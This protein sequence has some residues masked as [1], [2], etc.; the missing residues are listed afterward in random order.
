MT[1]FLACAGVLLV[2][3]LLGYT[4]QRLA[5]AEEPDM[6]EY[7][8]DDDIRR[9]A[10]SG[11]RMLALKWYRQLHA[12]DVKTAMTAVKAMTGRVASGH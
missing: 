4:V 12:T 5:P 3:L 1:T 9:L 11:K 10:L 7:C 8:T 6:P 2:F